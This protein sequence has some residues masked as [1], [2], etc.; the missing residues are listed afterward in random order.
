MKIAIHQ[1]YYDDSQ[2]RAIDPAFQP[3][4]N[5]ANPDP[6]WREYHVFRTEYLADNVREGEVTGYLSWK[7]GMKTRV[8]GRDFVDFI[9]RHPGRDV[10]FLNPHGIEPRRFRNVWLQGEHHHP[11]ILRL[12]RRVFRHVGIN[13]DPE[14]LEQPESQVLSRVVV[15]ELTHRRFSLALDCHSGFGARDRIWFPYAH[16]VKPF[17]NMPEVHAL[18]ELFEQTYPTHNYVVEP[19]S[20]QYLTHGDLWDHFYL[21]ARAAAGPERVFLPLTLEMGSW[22][23]VKKNPTQL[24]SRQGLFNP[25]PG[26]RLHRILRQHLLWLDFLARAVC[27]GDHWLP[28]GSQRLRHKKLALIEWYGWKAHS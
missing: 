26:H 11:G 27:G 20:R 17:P 15:E 7:F 22:L 19:Q 18:K 13:C 3:Y 14:S 1:I 5:R 10:W 24:F 23:W 9:K 28:H 12:A 25:R 8:R 6:V 16:T 2:W 21:N 4:D